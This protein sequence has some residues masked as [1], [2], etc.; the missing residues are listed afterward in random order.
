VNPSS[1]QLLSYL[2]ERHPDLLPDDFEA[3][4][5][6]AVGRLVSRVFGS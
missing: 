6:G 2:S 4:Q 3:P 5:P 1:G